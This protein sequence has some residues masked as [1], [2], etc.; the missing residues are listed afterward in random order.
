MPILERDS[1]LFD[2]ILLLLALVLNREPLFVEG[3]HLFLMLPVE[4]VRGVLL[5]LLKSFALGV[6]RLA[7]GE[8]R[9]MQLL[10]FLFEFETRRRPLLTTLLAFGERLL[11]D[12]S[13][14]FDLLDPQP[15]TA[16]F[17]IEL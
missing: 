1:F 13:V 2:F 17:V 6:E 12:F 8:Q 9:L 11:A 16:A 7:L 3:P 14:F 4:F 10:Q 5:V 15:N